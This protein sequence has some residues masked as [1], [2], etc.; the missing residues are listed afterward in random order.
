[1]CVFTAGN[2]I[3]QGDPSLPDIRPYPPHHMHLYFRC[4]CVCMYALFVFTFVF[5]SITAL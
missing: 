3:W 4:I 2:S 5:V 1:M